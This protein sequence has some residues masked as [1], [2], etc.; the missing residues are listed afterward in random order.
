MRERKISLGNQIVIRMRRRERADALLRASRCNESSALREIK[1]KRSIKKARGSLGGRNVVFMRMLPRGGGRE[2]EA[3]RE[4]GKTSW[5]KTWSVTPFSSV[6]SSK[7]SYDATRWSR[8]KSTWN[9]HSL[10]FERFWNSSKKKMVRHE[11]SLTEWNRLPLF[12]FFFFPYIREALQ[13]L[14]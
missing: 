4:N 6:S 3:V 8:N 2:G 7:L 5:Q 9:R 13:L 1:K 12:F 11:I 14:A 10:S